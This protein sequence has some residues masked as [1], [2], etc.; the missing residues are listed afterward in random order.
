MRLD[1][2]ARLG[3]Y[4][5]LGLLGSGGMGEVYRAKDGRL[6]RE[7]AIKV[8]PREFTSDRERLVRFEREARSSSA[9]NHRNIVTIHDFH[10][11]D[12]EA[13]LVMEL[14]Q[15]ESLRSMITRGPL[16]LRKLL[17]IASGIAQGLAAAHAAG[18]VHRDLKPENIMIAGDGTPKILDFGL[19]KESSS[20]PSH[21]DSTDLKVTTTGTIMGTAAYMS[22]E[23]GRGEP[24]DFRSDQFSLG[25]ILHEMASG[26]HPFR[27]GTPVETL[28]AILKD[29]PETLPATLPQPLHWIIE[30]CLEKNPLDRYGST[31]DLAHDVERLRDTSSDRIQISSPPKSQSM[32]K[33]TAVAMAAG[34]ALVATVLWV[35]LRGSGMDRSIGE[36]LY[37]DITTPELANISRGDMA[38]AVMISPDGRYLIINGVDVHGTSQLSLRDLRTGQTRLLVANGLP[39]CW[40]PDSRQFAYFTEGKLK[41]ISVDGGPPHTVCDALPE[42]TPTWLG[43]TILLT[44]F[45]TKPGLYRVPAAGGTLEL[46]KAP[47]I[48]PRPW[49]PHILPDGKRFLYTTIIPSG[50]DRDIEHELHLGNLDDTP[51]HLIARIPSRV[52]YSDGHL[53]FVREGTLIAQP[54]DLDTAQLTGEPKPLVERVDYFRSIGSSD[55]SVSSNGRLAWVSPPDPDRLV[56]MDRSGMEISEVGV[57]RLDG[58]GRISPDE[59]RYVGTLVDSAQGVGDLWT[60]A[61]DRESPQRL[62]FRLFDEKAPVW[63]PD[64]KTIFYRSDGGGGP[65]DIR[66]LHEGEQLGK[67]VYAGPSVEEPQD[68]SPDG[69][70]LLF[71]N[72]A[73][74][75]SDISVLPLDPPGEPRAFVATPFN[76]WSPRFSPDGRWV[77]WVSN[78]SGRPEVYIR[79]F[80]GSAP[81][82]RI[83]TG[84]GTLP[85]WQ[86]KGS[87]LYFLAPGGRLMVVAVDAGGQTS[88]PR[89]LFQSESLVGF[90]PSGDGA[91]FLVHLAG[92]SSGADVR[93]LMNWPARL[94][95][96]AVAAD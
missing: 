56:W 85:R 59:R 20:L 68:V 67:I 43:D 5:I 45:S 82:V 14:V 27:R 41:T 40:S 8:L 36:P 46:L 93:L 32:W 13:W 3:P 88:A 34:L 62:T 94:A 15:G 24:V 49:W 70:W 74:T 17:P 42:G 35:L 95:E 71:L 11:K 7:V 39:G 78:I 60:W 19:V 81:D 66:V 18:I 28:A 90:E 52:L 75:G 89:M 21:N 31:S 84:G 33:L 64:G 63:H 80:D 77:A 87:E 12:G 92:P 30:R 1:A 76:E 6:G 69:K 22:P 96:G 50:N 38:P 51:G 91:R 2:G 79:P 54:F 61:L 10:S 29:E 44:Q 65:P 25:M 48:N 4:E 72:Y 26:R 86:T 55:F 23:Q 47:G 53:L 37:A 9:L 58:P 83:S 73:F 57:A 16:P